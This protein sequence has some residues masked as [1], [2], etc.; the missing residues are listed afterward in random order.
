[1][2]TVVKSTLGGDAPIDLHFYYDISSMYSYF[3]FTL[4]K[5]YSSTLWKGK[6][7]WHLHPAVVG[8]IFKATGNTAPSLN[9]IK[10]NYT[11]R[12]TFRIS[13]YLDVPITFPTIFPMNSIYADRVLT[14]IKLKLPMKLI[15]STDA[16]YQAH[17][18]RGEDLNSKEK[19]K[20]CLAAVLSEGETNEILSITESTE[21]KE[22]LKETT[23]RAVSLG[24][25]GVPT[26]FVPRIQIPQSK[27]NNK[28]ETSPDGFEMFFGSDRLFLLAEF[29][30]LPWVGPHPEKSKTAFTSSL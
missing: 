18:G 8:F 7:N 4:L 27:Y 19:I 21:V 3:A 2:S 26:I 23:D 5:R 11:I 17:W 12:D 30:G 14:G 13:T 28:F 20:E 10:G 1:M 15:D 22:K 29:L 6:V 16:F 24:S 25:F 9:K